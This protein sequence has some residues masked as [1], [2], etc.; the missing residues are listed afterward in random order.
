MRRVR[1]EALAPGSADLRALV[2]DVRAGA[3][4]AIPT[5][6]EPRSTARVIRL[7][8]AIPSGLGTAPEIG[9]S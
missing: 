7:P 3:V 5:V 1:I 8:R 9:K 4:L 2:D 6:V